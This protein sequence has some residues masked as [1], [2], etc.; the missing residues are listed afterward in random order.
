M[1]FRDILLVLDTY[2]GPD[3]ALG[4][5]R[6]AGDRAGVGS[7]DIRFGMRDHAYRAAGIYWLTRCSDMLQQFSWRK[8]GRV[9][10][11]QEAAWCRSSSS[12]SRGVFQESVHWFPKSAV[13]EIFLGSTQIEG[14]FLIVPMAAV[15]GVSG[16]TTPMD[17]W[18]CGANRIWVWFTQPSPPAQSEGRPGS[19]SSI[20]SSSGGIAA[21][22]R[23]ALSRMPCQSSRSPSE[24]SP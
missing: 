15:E 21:D 4:D 20:R 8:A 2:S 17:K 19:G 7:T 9:S 1:V 14:L 16:D 18:S 22:R 23:H 10:R 5:G 24:L 12:S 3:A 13:A 6:C 11:T